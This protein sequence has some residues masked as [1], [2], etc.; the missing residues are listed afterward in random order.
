MTRQSEEDRGRRGK[1]GRIGGKLQ[2]VWHHVN[3]LE[4]AQ[5]PPAGC[6]ESLRHPN[7]RIRVRANN[8]HIEG[9]AMIGKKWSAWLHVAGVCVVVMPLAGCDDMASVARVPLA[10]VSDGMQQDCMAA[11]SG[12]T[13]FSWTAMPLADDKPLEASSG[14]V[15]AEALSPQ[16]RSA[17]IHHVVAYERFT[18]Q[19]DAAP[20]LPRVSVLVSADSARLSASSAWPSEEHRETRIA[21]VMFVSATANTASTVACNADGIPLHTARIEQE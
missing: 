1:S 5:A 3:A 4:H 18:A 13:G 2:P 17:L 20:S 8:P 11:S 10:W 15:N 6:R 16:L 19:A 14:G 21:S 12:D 9:E 7:E